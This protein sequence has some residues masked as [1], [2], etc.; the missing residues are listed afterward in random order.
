[1]SNQTQITT[2]RNYLPPPSD[3]EQATTKTRRGRVPQSHRGPTDAHRG[4]VLAVFSLSRQ[5]AVG[6]CGKKVN[7]S[8]TA[9]SRGVGGGRPSEISSTRQRESE[10]QL[11]VPALPTSKQFVV[12]LERREP[13]VLLFGTE[14]PSGAGL[15]SEGGRGLPA[16][17]AAEP[18]SSGLHPVADR[19]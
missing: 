3:S 2:T 8:S 19:G 18:W 5:R 9:S 17:Q 14:G 7:F 16:H 11:G 4:A 1:M 13:R 15:L 12:N 6:F 10:E